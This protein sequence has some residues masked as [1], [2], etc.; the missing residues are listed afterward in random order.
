MKPKGLAIAP[1]PTDDAPTLTPLARVTGFYRAFRVD[2]H[3]N[4]IL[5]LVVDPADVPEVVSHVI[6]TKGATLDIDMARVDYPIGD[7]LS[8]ILAGE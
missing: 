1:E 8:A 2:G 5:T 4:G 7:A 6:P 3:G